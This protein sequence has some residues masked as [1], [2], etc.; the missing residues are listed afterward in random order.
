MRKCCQRCEEVK[1][2]E[3]FYVDATKHD[4]LSSYCR[5]CR[6]RVSAD[7]A[8]ANPERHAEKCKR[9]RATPAKDKEYRLAYRLRN[10]TRFLAM[11]AA[12]QQKRRAHLVSAF[13]EDV[14]HA[15]LLEMADGVCG[16]CGEDV[17]PHHFHVD[18]IVPLSRGGEHS[19]A[20]TQVAHPSCNLRK[21]TRLPHELVMVEG[22]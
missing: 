1:R 12:R 5:E 13:I 21:M 22:R 2:P 15:D 9:N 11:K 8:R 17:D 10:E 18:H 3:A 6:R 14:N 4:G 16:I 19:Y 20:N 7:W